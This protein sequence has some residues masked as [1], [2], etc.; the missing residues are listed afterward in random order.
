MKVSLSKPVMAITSLA[1]IMLLSA[2]GATQQQTPFIGA[3][4]E[5]GAVLTRAP[6]TL[7]LYYQE[8][9]DVP[10]SSLML[11]GP[12]GNS[13]NLRGMHTMGANDLMIEI[14]DQVPNGEYT[15]QWKT[16][17][18]DDPTEYEGSYTFSVQ[19]N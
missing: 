12:G 13:L 18:G 2:C 11:L 10:R 16:F 14:N 19:A 17:V 1:A 15:V 7:R 3:E 8:L 4:P 5:V 6:R 9:P